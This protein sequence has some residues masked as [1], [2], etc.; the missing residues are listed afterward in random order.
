MPSKGRHTWHRLALPPPAFLYLSRAF[1]VK[2]L[3]LPLSSSLPSYLPHYTSDYFHSIALQFICIRT[4]TLNV[5]RT[6]TEVNLCT[7]NFI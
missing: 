1:V 4:E 6:Y 7:L 5:L 2:I 3:I